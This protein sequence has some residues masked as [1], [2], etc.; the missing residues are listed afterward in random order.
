MLNENHAIVKDQV[1]FC[2]IKCGECS[3]GNGGIAEAAMDLR[4]YI[5]MYDLASWAHELPGGRDV[6][7]ERF[8]QNLTWVEKW[9]SCPGCLNGGGSPECPIRICAK[10]KG[11]PSCSQCSDLG[12]CRNF[13]WLGE[14]GKM[15]KI[16][17]A[18][19]R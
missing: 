10:G 5:K 16:E 17:L 14:K 12:G 8:G 9:M 3:L 15:L 2:G 7:L 18:E 6:D 4:N 1:G 19:R 11:L 13:E